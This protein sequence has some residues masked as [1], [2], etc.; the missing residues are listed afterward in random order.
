MMIEEAQ[1]MV[2]RMEAAIEDKQDVNKMLKERSKL[3]KEIAKLKEE[4]E[5]LEEKG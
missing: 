1:S 4:K 3:H 5:S 2:N